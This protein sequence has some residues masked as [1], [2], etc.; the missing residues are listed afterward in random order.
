MENSKDVEVLKN[1][2]KR[3]ANELESKTLEVEDLKNKIGKLLKFK[4]AYEDLIEEL[5]VGRR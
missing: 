5:N 4:V 2:C 1:V 3:L